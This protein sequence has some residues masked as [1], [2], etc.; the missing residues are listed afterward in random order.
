MN[1]ISDEFKTSGLTDADGKYELRAV[2]GEYKVFI[3]KTQGGTALA[4][5]TDDPLF[6]MEEFEAGSPDAKSPNAPQQLVPDR[7]SNP[8]ATTLKVTVPEEGTSTA[9]FTNL[10][11]K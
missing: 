4:G 5:T 10:V 3:S 1:Y 6:G 9:D 7:F 2:P 8:A 11:S